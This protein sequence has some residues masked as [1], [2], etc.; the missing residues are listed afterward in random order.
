MTDD[1]QVAYRKMKCGPSCIGSLSPCPPFAIAKNHS[2]NNSTRYGSLERGRKEFWSVDCL[3][4]TVPR[5]R[6]S[7]PSS[8]FMG[9]G[10]CHAS[11]RPESPTEPLLDPDNHDKDDGPLPPAASAGSTIGMLAGCWWPSRE[12][13]SGGFAGPGRPSSFDQSLVASSSSYSRIVDPSSL[14]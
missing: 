8:G 1:G 13:V 5:R 7:L 12:N 10:T 4:D 9:P 6:S 14:N 11:N 2:R 3:I